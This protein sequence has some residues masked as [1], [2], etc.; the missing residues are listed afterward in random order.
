MITLYTPPN[1]NII[2][3]KGYI[4]NLLCACIECI[5]CMDIS[6]FQFIL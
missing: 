3:V 5:M 1:Y 6:A 2:V 4:L